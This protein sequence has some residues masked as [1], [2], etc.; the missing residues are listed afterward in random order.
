MNRLVKTVR[1]SLVLLGA[2][3]LAA[4][5]G[6]S[7]SGNSDS[8]GGGDSGGSTT[9]QVSLAVRGVDLSMLDTVEQAGGVFHDANGQS[10]EAMSLLH[11]YGANLVRLRL[12]V[13]PSSASGEAYGGGNSD[14][15]RT[16]ALA[17][18]AKAAGMQVMLDFHYSDF[19]VDPG[20]QVKPKAWA[21][22]SDSDLVAKV[23]SY[24]QEAMAALLAAGV[25]P[26]YVQIGNELNSGMLWPYGKNWADTNETVG[27]FDGL[28]TLLKAGIAG[29]QAAETAAGL[30][31]HAKII[32]HLA[33][34]ITNGSAN[35]TFRWWFDAITQRSV[36]FDVI[37][38]SYYPYWHG[39]LSALQTNLDDMVSRYS[40]PVMI[41]ETAYAFTTDNGDSLG[42][43]FSASD[44]TAGGYPATPAGQKQFLRDLR[45]VLS[46]VPNNQGLGFV[47][48]EPDWL[49][50]DGATWATQAGMD[51]IGTSGSEGNAWENQAL[52]DFNGDA[53]PALGQL[54]A[55]VE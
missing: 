37:G 29:V 4:C 33:N 26:T 10:Q 16:I 15:T 12:W 54:A 3:W 44:V 30:T 7:G 2:I 34:N 28:A 43:N 24:S 21:A 46:K 40:K 8:S 20:K 19:W 48:W 42:N 45:T 14:L 35:G 31:S 53:L 25:Q 1:W 6:G 47:Y 51:Y 38:V 18:R 39:T 11:G 23:Q 52:F 49:P 9:T 27:G 50:V 17:Q 22:L 41:V 5:G 32:L 36:P 13:D 55:S